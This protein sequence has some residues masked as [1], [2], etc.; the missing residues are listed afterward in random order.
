MK[1]A[2]RNIFANARALVTGHTGFK[3]SWLSL[4]LTQWGARVTGVSLGVPT[5]PSHFQAAGL[6]SLLE[7]H[8]LDIRDGPA[9]KGPCRK[10]SPT[11]FF[12][13]QRSP[14]CGARI[15]IR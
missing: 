9:L 7:D 5:E 1:D 12:I 15:R 6:R 10:L 2:A 3:G 8:Q 11:L 13:S 14:S 4:W